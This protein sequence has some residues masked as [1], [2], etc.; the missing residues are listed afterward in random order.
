LPSESLRI[1]ETITVRPNYR[2]SFRLSGGY[3]VTKFKNTGETTKTYTADS[4]FQWFP[5]RR[6]GISTEFYYT[7]LS[8]D[9][10]QSDDT[11]FSTMFRYLLRAWQFSAEYK[12]ANLKDAI[13]GEETK[14]N[15]VI[16][17]IARG[18]F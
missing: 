8:G 11:G 7:K 1:N 6:V 10:E 17:K 13:S 18:M 14:N 16:F 4:G 15:M 9:T 5:A 3:A 2:I 12:F